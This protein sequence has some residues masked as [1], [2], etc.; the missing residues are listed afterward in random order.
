MKAKPERAVSLSERLYRLLILLYPKE[1]RQVYSRDMLLAFRDFQRESHQQRNEHWNDLRFWSFLLRDL[2]TT[3]PDE[4]YK[5]FITQWKR[6]FSLEQKEYATMATG[7][8]FHLTVGQHTDIGRQRKN[9]EDSLLAIV[10]EDSAVLA[11]KGALFVVSDGLGGHNNGEVAS[12]LAVRTINEKYYEDTQESIPDALRF[13]IKQANA[14]IH[15][16]G[17]GMGT[18]CVVAVL[19]GDTVYI[20]NVGD[21]RAYLV[22]A[23]QLRQ[24]SRDHSFVADELR[25]GLITKEQARHHPQ[26]NV[27]TRCLGTEDDVEVDTFAEPVQEGDHLLLC[28]DGLTNL[29]D[30]EELVKIVHDFQPAQSV[31]QLINR[32]NEEGGPDNITAIVVQVSP[33]A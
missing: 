27:I 19:Q 8:P 9:N 6:L 4:H 15:Q 7:F 30:E 16:A 24:L 29:V 10:P 25:A 12:N 28:T 11:K 5:T 2:S 26:L 20:A 32:A 3:I 31:A 23:G 14:A 13:A 22:R 33:A 17:N 18:T 1:F 21:S